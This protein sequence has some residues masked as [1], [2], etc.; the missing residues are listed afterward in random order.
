M[1]QKQLQKLEKEKAHLL[2]RKKKI[3]TKEELAEL[4]IM[5]QGAADIYLS[6]FGTY[7]PGYFK[8]FNENKV[9]S[10]FKVINSLMKSY[11]DYEN[12]TKKQIDLAKKL[13]KNASKLE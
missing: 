2:G 6:K 13:I 10:S 8:Q 7:L 12:L 3:F 1:T 4:V 9:R 11:N 5:L